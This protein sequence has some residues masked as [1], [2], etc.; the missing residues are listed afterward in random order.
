[1]N[2]PPFDPNAPFQSVDSVKPAF[3]P[4]KPFTP[5]DA[6]T[7]QPSPSLMDQ[8]GSA[9]KN[10]LVSVPQKIGSTLI[11]PESMSGQLPLAGAVI[12]S[13][14][15]PGVGT[16]AGAGLGQIGSRM[17]DLAFGR[18]APAD[19]MN[20]GRE[21]IAPMAQ[22][23]AAGL[24]EV[25]GVKDFVQGAAQSLGRRALGIT[26]GMLKRTP[27]G[28]DTANQAAQEMLDQGVIRAGSSTKT[29]LGR[30][31]DVAQQSGSVIGDTLKAVGGSPVNTQD[32]ANSVLK[33]LT[34]EFSGGA[35]ESQNKVA[36]EIFDT[37]MAHGDGPIDMQSAQK[38]KDTLSQQAGNNWTTD[39][40]KAKMYQRAYGIV[41]DALENGIEAAAPKVSEATLPVVQP[42]LKTGDPHALF[43]YKDNF[44][45]GGAERSIYN[46]FGDQ[47]NPSIQKVG[48]GS[49][50]PKEAIDSAGIPI[51]GRQPN[52]KVP[53]VSKDLLE[54]YLSS[55]KTYGAA[56]RAIE[57]LTDKS[58]A[59]ASNSLLSLRGAAVGAGALASGN[60]AHTLE[61]LGGWEAARRVGTGTGFCCLKLC[62]QF[63]SCAS[64][65]SSFDCR[66]CQK[67][68]SKPMN[69]GATYGD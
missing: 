18:A 47:N 45:P 23:A 39:K 22:T 52:A 65:S 24:P 2:K 34:P 36:G 46:V 57:G 50:V 17:T 20:P 43:A 30:A 42:G 13:A 6:Q 33:Q 58:N 67:D 19:A 51:T 53:P 48:W 16:A 26:K 55:K 7:S 63:A 56:Q 35:Y 3:D 25:G 8:V 10:L 68:F 1:M 61:A 9:A 66:T 32:V 69:L 49:S 11:H 15:A 40:M 37:I 38:L 12:G 41:S 4:N 59:E 21:S 29:M 31:K 27:G 28:I 60:I 62:E 44:G 14:I 5:G 54:R 64:Q